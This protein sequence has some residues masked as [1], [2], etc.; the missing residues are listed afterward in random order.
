MSDMVVN[1]L[2]T[3]LVLF[4]V[5]LLNQKCEHNNMIDSL[6]SRCDSLQNKNEI[7]R[8]RATVPRYNIK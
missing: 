5:I 8:S 2:F 1:T 6:H 4:D 3:S 7:N